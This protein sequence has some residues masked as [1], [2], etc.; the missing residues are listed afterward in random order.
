[1]SI[2]IKPSTWK[3]G[4]R[5]AYSV[6]YDEALTELFDHVVPLHDELG[7]P[8]HVE[9][10][11]GQMGQVRQIGNSSYNGYHHMGPEKLRQLIDK[12]WGVGNHSWTHG[13]VEE[14]LHLG[15]YQAK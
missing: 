9:V 10:V 11:V 1:M 4:K 7:L 15:L 6:T 13:V 8:G 3:H 14:N 2:S 12:G 5:W